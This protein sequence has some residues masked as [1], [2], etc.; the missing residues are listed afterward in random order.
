MTEKEEALGADY[1]E[2]ALK[3]RNIPGYEVEQE[4]VPSCVM[5]RF[6]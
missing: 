6:L 1:L 3:G 5:H 2:H 4:A